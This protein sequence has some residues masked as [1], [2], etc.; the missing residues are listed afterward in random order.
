MTKED[1]LILRIEDS[2]KV[3]LRQAAVFRGESLTTFVLRACLRE[4]E[5]ILKKHGKNE[6]ERMRQMTKGFSGAVP[7]FFKALCLEAKRGGTSTYAVAGQ[8]LARHAGSLLLEEMEEDEAGE[9]LED[10]NDSAADENREAIL[11]WFDAHLPGCLKLV[12]GRRRGA[13]ASGVIGAAE[14]ELIEL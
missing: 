2:D 14:Q 5:K 12:P 3:K 8:E 7:S 11:A 13:F 1:V 6:E 9:L 10:L 4:A